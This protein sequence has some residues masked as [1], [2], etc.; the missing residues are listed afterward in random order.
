VNQQAWEDLVLDVGC[1]IEDGSGEYTLC[2]KAEEFYGGFYRWC[3]NKFD[4]EATAR[5]DLHARKLG[6]LYAVLVGR[7]D[8]LIRFEDIESG[9]EIAQY[10]AR[11]AQPLTESLDASPR[12]RQEQRLQNR[13]A[14]APG[15]E[16][17][18]L[19]RAL[20][21][22]VTELDSILMPMIASGMISEKDGH[23]YLPVTKVPAS[24]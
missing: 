10:C 24:H 22:S 6:L 7:G 20:H 1:A 3:R 8:H 18:G 2:P 5:T 21:V 17:R 14:E 9:A 19:Y 4:S 13:V 23:F 12:R 11:V 16:K 15:V